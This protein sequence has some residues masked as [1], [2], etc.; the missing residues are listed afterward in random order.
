MFV[1]QHKSWGIF[2]PLMTTCI[3]K[4]KPFGWVFFC[5]QNPVGLG[6]FL[7][8]Q[9]EIYIGNVFSK[10]TDPSNNSYNLAN[11]MK[12]TTN[13]K[14]GNALK[15]HRNDSIIGHMRPVVHS[16]CRVFWTIEDIRKPALSFS[17]HS[18]T[19]IQLHTPYLFQYHQNTLK[20]HSHHKLDNFRKN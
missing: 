18:L 11:S 7:K 2:L 5:S 1:S 4:K 10:H 6:W 12:L 3:C 15:R 14:T 20:L 17:V 16:Y 8:I 13:S 9:F 19:T